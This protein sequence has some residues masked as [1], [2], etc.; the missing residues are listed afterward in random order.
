[1][2]FDQTGRHGEVAAR[3]FDPVKY[4]KLALVC[5]VSDKLTDVATG[6]AESEWLCKRRFR[7]RGRA[8]A[9]SQVWHPS[10]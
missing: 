4:R 7:L 2:G 10:Y 8:E 9:I 3:Y 6:E 1:M 5:S